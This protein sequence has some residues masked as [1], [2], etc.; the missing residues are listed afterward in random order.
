MKRAQVLLTALAFLCA[1]VSFVSAQ[2]TLIAPPT[3]PT[4]IPTN[5]N[6]MNLQGQYFSLIDQY[7]DQEQKYIVAKNQ[8]LQLNTLAS[9]ELAVKETRTLLTLR[10]DIF[11]VYIDILNE[12][13][14][15]GKGIPLENKNPEQIA[16]TLLKEKV[17]VHRTNTESALDRFALDQESTNFF[18]TVKDL[19]S[20]TYYTL[21]L[22]KIGKIQ[23]AYD[24]LFFVRDAVKGYIDTQTLSSAVRSEKERGFAEI[25]RTLDNVN[26]NFTP[27]KNDVF[28]NPGAG[29]LSDY[30][31]LSQELNPTYSQMNQVIQFLEE[32]RK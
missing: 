11:L 17:R 18:P 31:K 15:Q 20:H 23:V 21:S 9:Q 4:N 25:E 13:L 19:E 12:E 16:L 2:E 26:A 8:Y 5:Q 27:V 28:K 7:R 6:L 29:S 32:I 10:A 22:I 1:L 24:K 3:V 30:S 14:S